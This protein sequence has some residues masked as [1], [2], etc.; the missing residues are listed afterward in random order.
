[1]THGA[2]G[3]PL[4]SVGPATDPTVFYTIPNNVFLLDR[5]ASQKTKTAS[6]SINLKTGV[7]TATFD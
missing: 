7:M 1:M 5:R 3:D 2:I 4:S 6:F